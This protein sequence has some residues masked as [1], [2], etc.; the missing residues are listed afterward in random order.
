[1]GEVVELP[2]PADAFREALAAGLAPD[3]V[4]AAVVEAF[5]RTTA[6]QLKSLLDDAVNAALQRTEED[7]LE[8]E[9]A[10]HPYWRENL[11]EAGFLAVAQREALGKDGGK[12]QRFCGGKCRRAFHSAARIW[13][14]REIAEGR[15]SVEELRV[16]L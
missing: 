12:P 10:L 1:M 3:D 15:L 8:Y 13:A 14:E 7:R 16:V 6:R 9:A 11:D 2:T 5:P 4:F